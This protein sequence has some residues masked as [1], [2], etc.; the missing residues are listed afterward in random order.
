MRRTLRTYLNVN[1][2]P[3][4]AARALGVHKNT[5]RY[6]IQRAEEMLGHPIGANRLKLELALEYADTYGPAIHE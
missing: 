2:S 4:A 1:R 6:R 5:V 3:D